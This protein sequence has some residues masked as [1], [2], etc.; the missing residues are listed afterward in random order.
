MVDRDQRDVRGDAA[1]PGGRGEPM[2]LRLLALAMDSLAEAV[3]VGDAEGRVAWLNP[4]ACRLLA[5]SRESVVRQPFF[6]VIL[7]FDETTGVSLDGDVFHCLEEGIPFQL[8]GRAES[9]RPNGDRIPLDGAISPIMDESGR[10]RGFVAVLRDISELKAQEHA[11]RKAVDTMR[12][13]FEHAS[14]GINIYEEDHVNHTRRLIDC[15]ER[16]AEMAGRTKE[17]LLRIGNTT[18]LQR[19]IGPVTPALDEITLRRERL[20][21][22]GLISWIRPDGRENI[23]EYAAMPVEIDGRPCTI[24]LDRDITESVKMQE[25]L[26]QRAQELEA[27]ARAL[28]EKTAQLEA[29]NEE[30]EAFSYTVAHD[31]KTPL[32][33]VSGLAEFVATGEADQLSLEARGYLEQIVQHSKKMRDIIDA[34][35]VL[36][37]AR[38]KEVAFEPLDM[39]EI[40]G[41]ALGQLEDLARSRGAQVAVPGSWPPALGYAPWVE[42]VWV[43]YISNAIK[44]GGDPPVVELGADVQPDGKVSFWVRD[45][46]PGL[47]EQEQARLFARFTRLR[48]DDAQGHGLGLS[49]VRRLVERMGGEVGVVSAPGQGS[50]FSFTLPLVPAQEGG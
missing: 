47:S 7:L 40:V 44:Y 42:Q 21:Y 25:T 18:P 4:A 37:E 31:L 20:P 49:I 9:R 17:E 13:V 35:L 2:D 16:Y 48:R 39:C 12:F 43:N 36:A 26:R 30:L 34:L 22:R 27:L 15:N 45:Y 5:L 50:R 6:D 8:N 46:G 1:L 41:E 14:D 29:Q 24:G 23:I 3:I 10:P 33:M 19:K 11:L 38:F 28:E 32:A